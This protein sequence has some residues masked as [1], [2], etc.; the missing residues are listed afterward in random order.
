MSAQHRKGGV[1]LFRNG[2][3]EEIFYLFSGALAGPFSHRVFV[4]LPL[5]R[6]AP[7]FDVDPSVTSDTAGIGFPRR[8]GCPW[9]A[10]LS[11]VLLGR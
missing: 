10:T 1:S 5:F 7:P 8:G 6:L 3:G 11:P 9:L 4:F 2:Q